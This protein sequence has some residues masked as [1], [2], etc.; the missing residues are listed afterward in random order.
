MNAAEIFGEN[1]FDDSVM[2]EFL[3]KKIFQQLKR[4]LIVESIWILP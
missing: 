4:T 1:V 2:E 3:P